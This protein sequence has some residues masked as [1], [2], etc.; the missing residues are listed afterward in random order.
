MN[1]EI[2]EP[3]NEVEAEMA[4]VARACLIHALDQS[5][6][7]AIKITVDTDQGEAP[8]LYLPPRAL[9]FF[10]EVLQQMVRREPVVLVPQK[11]ELSTQEAAAF[12]NVSRPFV[13]KQIEAGRLKHRL[14]NRHRR[15]EFEELVKYQ[16]EQKM[17]S[18][19]ALKKLRQVSD[20][21]GEE[22]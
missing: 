20:D 13:I 3:A 12:L 6:A 17:R 16:D 11:H 7:E 22:L 15:I 4:A 8:V 14:V 10:A 5:K 21:I 2:L 18:E 1:Q 19:Q 9:R